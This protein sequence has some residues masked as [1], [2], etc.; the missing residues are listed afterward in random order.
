LNV[1]PYGV[2]ADALWSR[3]HGEDS[4]YDLIWYSAGKITD[5]GYQVEL[6]IPFS[7]LRFPGKSEQTWKVEFWRHHYRASHHNISW[8]A[9]DRDNDCWACQWGTVTGIRDV[10]PGRGIEILPSVLAYQ[11]GSLAGNGSPESPFDFDNDDPDG[12]M[13]LNAKYSLSSSATVEATYNPD[14]SQVEADAAQ[15]DVNSNFALFYSERRPFFQEGSDLFNTYFDAVYTRTINDPEF[16]AKFT[17][18]ARRLSAAYLVAYDENT[19]YTLPFEERSSYVL[20]DKSVSNILRSKLTFGSQSYVGIIATD[21]RVTDGDG[22][23]TLAGLDG[24]FQLTKSWQL[25]WQML[26]SN[27]DEPNDTAGT[28]HLDGIAFDGGKH[29]AMFDGESYSGHGLYGILSRNDRNSDGSISY[30]QRSE[31]FRADNG[32]EPRNNQRRVNTSG[33]YWFRRDEG[34]LQYVRPSWEAGRAWNMDGLKKDE[35]LRLNLSWQLR[36]GQA[37]FHTQYMVSSEHLGG[38]EFKGINSFHMCANARS[39]GNLLHYGGH[40]E[41]GKQ[42]ARRNLLLGRETTVGLWLDIRPIDR[43][44]IENWYDYSVNKELITDATLFEGYILRTR[45][46][47][48]MTRCLSLRMVMQYDNF[49]RRWDFDPLVTYRLNPF[50]VLYLGSSYDYNR[51]TGIGDDGLGQSTRLA[52]RQIFLKM[53]YLFQI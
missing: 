15:I 38:I 32:Y 50:S 39:L 49:N 20:G 43:I 33:G 41:Y 17:G 40:I 16:A 12:Q 5:S 8:A 45:W 47:V 21:R 27:T 29:T 4:G 46:S 10:S 7:S 34:L 31:T 30:T 35:W 22:A 19:P 36:S 44:L 11:S 28:S 51:F 52:D 24:R 6:A 53:Q 14:F 23:G 26:A 42:I 2:Q 18:R 37:Y 3:G 9:Y 25:G 13:S 1:N 48:Q